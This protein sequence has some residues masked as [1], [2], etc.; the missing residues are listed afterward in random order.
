MEQAVPLLSSCGESY[1]EWSSFSS[2]VVHNSC[3]NMISAVSTSEGGS[4]ACVWKD[5]LGDQFCLSFYN[6]RLLSLIMSVARSFLEGSFSI[7][8]LTKP[9]AL[10]ASPLNLRRFFRM[11][12]ENIWHHYLAYICKLILPRKG[13]MCEH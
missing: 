6:W 10:P 11:E 12:D 9:S 3:K 5:L 13:N 8:S 7:S 4:Q 1:S 2:Q